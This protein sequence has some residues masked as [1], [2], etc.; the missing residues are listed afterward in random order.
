MGGEVAEE[1]PRRCLKFVAST[2]SKLFESL[3]VAVQGESASDKVIRSRNSTKGAAVVPFAR[4]QDSAGPC[5]WRKKSGLCQ[6]GR[7]C[8]RERG[9]TNPYKLTDT[10]PV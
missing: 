9:V 8:L 7:P 3:Q 4:C 2:A 10:D 5:K 1:L 6:E